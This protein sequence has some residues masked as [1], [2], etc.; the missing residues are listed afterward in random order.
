MEWMVI[1][2]LEVHST[3]ALGVQ[4]GDSYVA[5]EDCLA[6]L[7]EILE[8]LLNEDKTAQ[9]YRRTLGFS[10]VIKKDL[11]PLLI[12]TKD[13]VKVLDATVRV[14]VNLT[15][16][17]E[18]LLAVEPA[19]R[20][21]AG[22]I[23]V[24][25][26]NHLLVTS[27]EAFADARVTRC[28]VEH[29]RGCL[30]KEADLSPA[31][32]DSIN[33]CLLLL[34]NV[35]HIPQWWGN[36]GQRCRLQNQIMW[37]LFTHS[38][39][40]VM[41]SLIT[42]PHKSR[43]AVTLV[44]LVAL[45][46]KD[47][48]VGLLQKLLNQ[49]FEA[50]LSDSSEDNE[51]NTSPRGS[52]NS[53]PVLTSDPT[54]DSSDNGGGSVEKMSSLSSADCDSDFKRKTRKQ[55]RLSPSDD[56]GAAM[57]SIQALRPARRKERPSVDSGQSSLL[58]SPARKGGQPGCPK[59]SPS[60]SDAVD[61]GYVTQA[62]NQESVS[63]SSNE[64]D[65]PDFKRPVHQ[66]PHMVQKSRPN[67]SKVAGPQDKKELRRK[68]LVKRSK[69]SM[70]NVKALVH[71]TPMDEDIFHL[72]KE[73]TVDFL[74]KGYGC[75]VRELYRQ[76]VD[77][78]S[79]AQLV[80][81]SHFFWL[82]TYFL[83]FAA[84]LELDFKHVSEVLSWDVMAYLVYEGAHVCEQL[85]TAAF[86]PGQDVKPYLRRMHLVVTAIREFLERV[87]AFK[88]MPHL[89]PENREHLQ[90]L[91]LKVAAMEDLKGLFALLL[92]QYKPGVHSKQFLQDLVVTN[93]ALMLFLDDVYKQPEYR[94][95]ASLGQHVEL[96]ATVDMMHKYGLL[97]EDFRENG[98][99]VND[100]VFTMMHHVAGDMGQASALFQPGILKTFSHIWETDFG[101]CDDWSDLIG[102]VVNK[103]VNAPQRA[104][105]LPE[106]VRAPAESV[107][108]PLGAD[109]AGWSRED[110]EKLSWF[111]CRSCDG[112]DPVG[113]VRQLFAEDGVTKPRADIIR[114]LF[115]Q[116]VISPER[117]EQ[118]LKTEAAR[119]ALD[120]SQ[121]SGSAVA[122]DVGGVRMD[123][124]SEGERGADENRPSS[125]DDMKELIGE[126]RAE[127]MG[128]VVAWLQRLLLETCHVKLC[129][130]RGG[131][132]EGD[133]VTEPIPLVH[134]MLRQSIPVVPWSGRQ[135][136]AMQRPC[137]AQLLHRLG[138]H[139]PADSGKAFAR[140]PDFWTAD[141]VYAAAERLGPVDVSALKF[142]V[143]LL[144]AAEQR[145][146]D[147]DEEM[148]VSEASVPR[149]LAPFAVSR[150]KQMQSSVGRFTP[151]PNSVPNW[152]QLVAQTK[153][154]TPTLQPAGGCN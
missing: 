130:A 32:C 81:T 87:T 127:G 27:K 98:E 41:I 97:L 69:T 107:S 54:S 92:G 140:V 47:Q 28:V 2:P 11:L 128:D 67:S 18:C 117:H 84:Q 77:N 103:F 110:W 114:Q 40:K 99:F 16:P 83:K 72:L 20:T 150:P 146:S 121:E 108:G 60:P 151:V 145:P 113:R 58:S 17:A 149:D 106:D 138:F 109:D 135:R 86:F 134:A 7:N 65:A 4:V 112:Q 132:A 39:D 49:W 45:M 115:V 119:C 142:D 133:A 64:D 35:L 6:V 126:L 57:D 100:C 52:V 66:K 10:Q 122:G 31:E 22:R 8:K 102:Y 62:E 38:V 48:Q 124:S 154:A 25:E 136:A 74:L 94:G 90:K 61:C 76:L 55:C 123:E 15:L 21:D 14:L 71:H 24:F 1:N 131:P 125:S 89:S 105:A 12:N 116:K 30:E 78:V 91:Q 111:Y 75:L 3:F 9:K 33:N 129:V 43:W 23:A 141:A 51:S 120:C 19:C 137:F 88:R 56:G 152:L 59:L 13:N 118:L 101:V 85:E 53:S 79:G 73:F 143:K 139:L 70:V 80:D 93:H 68:K 34:R 44:Q 153:R 26:I 144:R 36:G 29:M 96:F 147:D 148:A 82:V 63:T 50:S 46:Y 95:P 37:N 42:G 104:K 5:N